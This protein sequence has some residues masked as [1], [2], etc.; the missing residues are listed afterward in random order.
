MNS[1]L[2]KTVLRIFLASPQNR[3]TACFSNRKEHYNRYETHGIKDGYHYHNSIVIHV[4]CREGRQLFVK[5]VSNSFI[6]LIF[7]DIK[8]KL[9]HKF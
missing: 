5:Y 7:G 6:L 1:S 4:I 9:L 2:P 8:T 3:V